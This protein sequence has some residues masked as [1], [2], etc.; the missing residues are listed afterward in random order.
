MVRVWIYPKASKPD[1]M[2][3]RNGVCEREGYRITHGF[4]D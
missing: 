3:D 1:S 4:L 2:A